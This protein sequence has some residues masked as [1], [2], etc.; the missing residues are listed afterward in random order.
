MGKLYQYEV[1]EQRDN[2][3]TKLM[4]L[5]GKNKKVLEIGSSSGSQT[6]TMTEKLGCTVHAVEIDPNAAEHARPYCASMIVGSV[7]SMTTEDLAAGAPYD[8]ILFADVL[9]HLYDPRAAIEKVRPLLAPGGY[10]LVSIPNVT[11]SALV[12]EMMQGRFEYRDYG[13]LDSTHIRFFDRMAVLKLFEQAQYHIDHLEPVVVKPA[14]TEFA[15][16][17][18]SE[19]DQAMFDYMRRRNPDSDTF[20][21]VVRAYPVSTELESLSALRASR[22]HIEDLEHVLAMH[23]TDIGELRARLAR[24]DSEIEWMSR[25][26]WVRIARYLRSKL[27]PVMPAPDSGKADR[28]NYSLRD[29]S[30]QGR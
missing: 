29:A 6:R 7:E 16:Q 22:R 19:S 9:E 23:K 8:V 30:S 12:F 21:F 13:L 24:R 1:D 20:Q 14:D 2:A 27:K 4:R 11:H 28:S 5:V 26:P 3:P 15:T 18:A 10:L 17:L 25:R